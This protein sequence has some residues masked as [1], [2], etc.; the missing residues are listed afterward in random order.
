M[1]VCAWE[2]GEPD[3]SGEL[4]RWVRLSGEDPREWTKCV[5]ATEASLTGSVILL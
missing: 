3:V 4:Y 1:W 2:E 5:K